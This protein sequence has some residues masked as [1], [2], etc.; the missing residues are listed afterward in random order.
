MAA[1]NATKSYIDGNSQT[2]GVGT[3]PILELEKI[4][5][6]KDGPF[7]ADPFVFLGRR[8]R[9]GE[10]LQACYDDERGLLDESYVYDAKVVGVHIG[11]AADGI[12]S[13]L[14]LRPDGYEHEDYVDISKLTVLKVFE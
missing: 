11:S 8:I 4:S 1:L 12:E 7:F 13:S 9:V 5:C 14:L 6:W 10:L 2:W 3:V